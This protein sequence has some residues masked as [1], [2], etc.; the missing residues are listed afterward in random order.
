MMDRPERCRISTSCESFFSFDN[1]AAGCRFLADQA[2]K[3]ETKQW[4]LE[5]QEDETDATLPKD[6]AAWNLKDDSESTAD[7]HYYYYHC[8]DG[9]PSS[10]SADG[11]CEN[12]RLLRDKLVRTRRLLA[13]I[14]SSVR[15]LAEQHRVRADELTDARQRLRLAEQRGRLL[16]QKLEEP[17][18]LLAKENVDLR[19]QLA[20]TRA[21]FERLDLESER[22]ITDMSNLLEQL[23]D[24]L[25][26]KERQLFVAYAQ[27]DHNRKQAEQYA[28]KIRHADAHAA[29]QQD[30]IEGLQNQ[31]DKQ[32]AK[33]RVCSKHRDDLLLKSA[34]LSHELVWF[35]RETMR[36]REYIRQQIEQLRRHVGHQQQQQL[37]ENML[38]TTLRNKIQEV[39]VGERRE[40]KS[41]IYSNF[42]FFYLLTSFQEAIDEREMAN[43]MLQLRLDDLKLGG[44]EQQQQQQPSPPPQLNYRHSFD[45]GSNAVSNA[46]TRSNRLYKSVRLK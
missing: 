17:S 41:T 6:D 39:E 36:E 35:K 37:D 18:A 25:A 4:K 15:R 30:I 20:E 32:K 29:T 7:Y 34:S 2:E 14:D 9:D 43:R 24:A 46:V 22:R 10:S 27:L 8:S 5:E 28:A 40:E 23:Q 42:V 33:S 19:G 1:N 3:K 38:I 11:G 31:L 21:Y 13:E 12:C 45:Q 44:S 16:E 26:E